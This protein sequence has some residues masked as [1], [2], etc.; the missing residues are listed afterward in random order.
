MFSK[1]FLGLFH[2]IILLIISPSG[3]AIK[4]YNASDLINVL[5]GDNNKNLRTW[6]S[7]IYSESEFKSIN[8]NTLIQH[9]TGHNIEEYLQDIDWK[10]NL[11][12]AKIFAEQYTSI[13][14]ETCWYL[15]YDEQVIVLVDEN[16]Y[17]ERIKSLKEDCNL[18]YHRTLLES[19]LKKELNIPESRELTLSELKQRKANLDIVR[20]NHWIGDISKYSDSETEKDELFRK[21]NNALD[22]YLNMYNEKSV[23]NNY[24]LFTLMGML[25]YYPEKLNKPVDFYNSLI[26]LLFP[27]KGVSNEN[28]K[29]LGK[30]IYEWFLANNDSFLGEWRIDDID[31]AE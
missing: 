15:F 24:F 27:D 21:I 31:N 3:N 25:Y 6:K 19:Q 8:Q 14:N 10:N 12:I 1:F 2:F 20:S 28:K 22:T 26:K 30:L 9:F 5:I 4:L 29:A 23:G 13:L 7:E 18:K 16:N 11:T 17:N